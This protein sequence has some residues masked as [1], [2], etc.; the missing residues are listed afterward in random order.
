VRMSGLR[1]HMEYQIKQ[2]KGRIKSALLTCGQ[3]PPCVHA[4]QVFR[5][6]TA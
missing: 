2:R 5:C 6:D 3:C 4:V 1:K